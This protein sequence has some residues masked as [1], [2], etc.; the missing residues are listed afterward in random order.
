LCAESLESI[1]NA[2]Y[3]RIT[4]SELG[5]K[6]LLYSSRA[7]SFFLANGQSYNPDSCSLIL[8]D[9]K[10]LITFLTAGEKP[11]IWTGPRVARHDLLVG[12]PSVLLCI[13]LFFI[14]IAHVS[15]FSHKP[16]T[17]AQNLNEEHLPV[18]YQGGLLG[19][20]ALWD[21]CNIWDVVKSCARV[22]KWAFARRGDE[23]SWDRPNAAAS[24][25]V[26]EQTVEM[27]N[28]QDIRPI[29]GMG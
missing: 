15:V 12:F 14:S 29:S 23:T 1:S 6:G 19:C 8:T 4:S 3:R 27:I 17:T 21:A 13:E 24:A 11:V 2:V 25:T 18:V 5:S 10:L 28:K 22:I 26:R 9:T 20:R 7:V 16:F